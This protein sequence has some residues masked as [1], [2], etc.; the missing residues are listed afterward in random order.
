MDLDVAFA[1]P[2]DVIIGRVDELNTT[3]KPDGRFYWHIKIIE[4]QSKEYAL[5]MP[6]SGNHL[7]L[8]KF[9]IDI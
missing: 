4:L 8:A 1:I 2:R 6:K 7:S 5:Q 9:E 3:E